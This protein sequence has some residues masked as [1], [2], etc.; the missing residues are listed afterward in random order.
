MRTIYRNIETLVASGVPIEGERGVGYLLREPIFLP[1]MTLTPG[2]LR[3]LH[4]GMEVVRQTGDAELATAAER[5]VGK[6]GAVLPSD[7]RALQP[8]RDLAVYAALAAP[9]CEHLGPLR[10]AVAD[11]R[12]LQIGYLD[13]D[14]RR[15]ERRIR[16]LQTEF[17]RIWTCPA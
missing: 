16:P 13:L 7:R 15:T 3:A 8:L 9:A 5:L 6:I 14:G 12:I 11:H 4:L 2:E 1:P 17:C 10:R